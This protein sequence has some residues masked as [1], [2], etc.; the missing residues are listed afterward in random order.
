MLLLVAIGLAVFA[1]LKLRAA[2]KVTAAVMA[3]LSIGAFVWYFSSDS[4]NTSFTGMT[5][6]VVTLFVLAV[7]SQRLRMPAADGQQ[8][9]RGGAG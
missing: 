9:R 3:G 8:Y 6:Y 4:V 5:P 2:E 1:V 7:F